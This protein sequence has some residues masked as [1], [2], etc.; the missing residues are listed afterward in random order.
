MDESVIRSKMD[1]TIH[2]LEDNLRMLR[3]S[4]AS[5]SLIE[6]IKIEA[7]GTLMPLNQLAN[8]SVVDAKM[9]LV[10]PWDKTLIDAIIKG[11]GAANVGLTPIQDE[12]IVRISVPDLTEERRRDLTKVV[13]KFEEEAKV[14]LRSIRKEMIEQMKNDK[15]A[16]KDDVSLVTDTADKVIKEYN[17]KVV[18]LS[19]KKR[20]EMLTV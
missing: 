19:D 11:I 13:G 6:N 8:I 4:R 3:T 5:A 20:Q 17:E 15:E 1:K 7:Y 9:I 16:T 14:A 18:R 2:V 10:Q 12:G